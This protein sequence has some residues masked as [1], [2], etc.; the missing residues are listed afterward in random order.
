MTSVT[1]S[2]E[3]NYRHVIERAVPAHLL[4]LMSEEVRKK[5]YEFRLD[6]DQK[7]NVAAVAPL[8][9]VNQFHVSYVAKAVDDIAGQLMRELTD[10]DP[11][12]GLYTCVMF[13]LTLVDEGF[14][15]DKTNMAV[16]VSLMLLADA[17]NDS[18][19][20]KGNEAV[21]EQKK[22]KWKARGRR[23]LGRANRFGLY[24][25]RKELQLIA[26]GEV[27]WKH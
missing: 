15:A 20:D 24:G 1:S 6:V 10:D 13:I 12:E 16:L 8:T 25:V 22:A 21:I 14:L 26:P 3:G 19:D 18:K 9:E 17:E 5:G 23:M 2:I 4:Y 27:R 7:L 11:V